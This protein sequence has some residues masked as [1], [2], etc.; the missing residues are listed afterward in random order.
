MAEG[1]VPPLR[2]LAEEEFDLFLISNQPSHA[3]AKTSLENI[4]EIHRRFKAFMDENGVAFREYY[5]C[6]HHPKG[7][8]PGF[9]GPCECRKPSAFFIRKAVKERGVEAGRSWMVGDRD[10]DVR[11]GS[12]G[13]CR[14]VLILNKHSA[15]KRGEARPDFTAA[16]LAEAVEIILKNRERRYDHG[17]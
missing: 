17:A 16:T 15:S 13:G 7:V 1:V 10:S 5:Y 6:Y 4:R 14:T 3:K 8:R 9:S 12:D 11:C 2:R